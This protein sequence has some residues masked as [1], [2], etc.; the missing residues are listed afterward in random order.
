[1]FYL[2]LCRELCLY[3]GAVDA[4]KST[5]TRILKAGVS[6]LIY[7]GGSKEIFLTDPDSTETRLVRR[8]GFI[9][10]ALEQGASLVPVF[11]F[12]EKWLYRRWRLPTWFSDFFMQMFRLPLII[13]WGRFFT[14]IPHRRQ[15]AMVYGKP[16]P[17]KKVES[18]RDEDVAELN[19]QYEAELKRIFEKYK[20]QYGYDQKETFTFI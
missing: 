12:G 18:P 1:M 11:V 17:V 9:R 13:F 16:I 2:P 20:T 15:L 8:T 19:E 4:D 6:L 10:L 7:P 3:C 14:Y 5:A